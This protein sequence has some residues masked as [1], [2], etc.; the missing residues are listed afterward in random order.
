[1][2]RTRVLPALLLGAVALAG[3][4]HGDNFGSMIFGGY[5]GVC[6]LIHVV[7]VVMALV[8][9]ANSTADTGS[10]VLWGAAVFFFPVVGLIA[11]WL[12]GPKS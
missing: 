12:W 11:W 3:C 6:W 4:G 5:G 7:L 9:I 8:K 2:N 1:M 10:K